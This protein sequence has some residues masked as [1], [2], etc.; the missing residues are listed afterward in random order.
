MN[1]IREIFSRISIYTIGITTAA[2]SLPQFVVAQASWQASWLPSEGPKQTDLD[3]L[4]KTGLN[5]AIIFAAVVAVAFLIFSGFRYMTAG[6]DASKVEEAQ[7]GLANAL[8]GLVIAIAA[9]I[10]VNFVLG[11]FGMQTRSITIN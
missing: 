1:S 2:L 3:E 11:L 6:G 9:A 10:I 7:K 4:I 5:T 8:I